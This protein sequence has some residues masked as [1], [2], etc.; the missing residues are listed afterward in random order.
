MAP[1]IANLLSKRLMFP[2]F[3]ALHS[4][5]AFASAV[6]SASGVVVKSHFCWALAAIM[7]MRATRVNN[8]F[9]MARYLVRSLTILSPFFIR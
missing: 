3:V 1:S 9:F 8:T 2:D 6:E 4:D 5:V 7:L